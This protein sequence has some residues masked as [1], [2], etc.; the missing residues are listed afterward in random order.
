MALASTT[1]L[2]LLA[3]T[4]PPA[5]AAHVPAG[6]TA[7]APAPSTAPRAIVPDAPHGT[8]ISAAILRAEGFDRA[9]LVRALQLRLPTLTILAAADEA[10]PA[11]DGSLRAFIELHRASPTQIQLTLIL[12]DGR[13]YLRDLEVDADAPARP[14]ASALANLVAG[15]EDDTA[16]PDK[17]DVPLPPALVA[18][19]PQP[20]PAASCPACETCPACPGPPPPPPPRWELAPMLRG[21]ASLGLTR[22][23]GLRGA[24]FG[25]GLDARA[26]S[27]LLLGLDLQATTRV[28]DRFQVQRL[29]VAVAVGYA[30]R[31]GAFELPLAVLLGVEPWR[32]ASDVGAVKISSHAGRPGALLGLGL[33]LSPGFIAPLGTRGA[34]L[35]AGLRVELWASGEPAGGLRRPEIHLPSG[36]ATSLGGAE[37]H[38]GLELGV[39]IPAGKPPQRRPNN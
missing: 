16:V 9:E 25:L 7:S 10:P 22:I 26:P 37:L 36:G 3:L 28:V 34:R 14:A 17:K 13:A 12:A 32:L 1:A 4:S 27:G 20:V 21:G 6:S 15:I 24:G 5:D 39:W 29:R 19:A 11:A 31:R 8:R 35:R 23:A 18:P 38:L 2:A 30:L 33:R